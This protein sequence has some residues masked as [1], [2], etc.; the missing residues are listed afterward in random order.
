MSEPVL[1]GVASR[2]AGTIYEAWG[3]MEAVADGQG[4]LYQDP[5]AA[6]QSH[7]WDLSKLLEHELRSL[8]CDCADVCESRRQMHETRMG[9]ANEAGKCGAAIRH[10][11]LAVTGQSSVCLKCDGRGCG[12]CDRGERRYERRA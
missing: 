9:V 8:V 11:M 6:R 4:H 7:L 12:H 5:D 10:A 3:D 2:I 1:R